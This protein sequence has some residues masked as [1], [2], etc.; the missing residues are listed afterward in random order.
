[1][2]YSGGLFT[3]IYKKQVLFVIF[4]WYQR[5]Q[6]LFIEIFGSSYGSLNRTAEPTI[7]G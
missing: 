7:M 5:V 6:T 4:T 2:I 3:L 1:M